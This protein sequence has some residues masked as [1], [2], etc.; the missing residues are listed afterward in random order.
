M[1]YDTH[2]DC[3]DL[4]IVKVDCDEIVHV[5]ECNTSIN[6]IGNT[7]DGYT[8]ISSDMMPNSSDF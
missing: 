5:V 4:E 7:L 1:C 2:E 8:L 6:V 3:S